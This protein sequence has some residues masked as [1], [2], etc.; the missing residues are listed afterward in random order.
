MVE[1]Q[2]AHPVDKQREDVVDTA[3]FHIV[4][5]NKYIEN[6]NIELEFVTSN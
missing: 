2:N 5:R 3:Q 1:H 4:S 6:E